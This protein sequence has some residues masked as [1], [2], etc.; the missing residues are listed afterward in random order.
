ML[1]PED[2][3]HLTD[4]L[5]DFPANLADL[6]VANISPAWI[7]DLA[8]EWV[9]VLRGASSETTVCAYD[10]AGLGW[11]DP[12]HGTAGIDAIRPLV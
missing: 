11:S 3:L 6:I 8:P 1:D 9:R 5:S 2:F 10:R 7:S 4:F 12:Q